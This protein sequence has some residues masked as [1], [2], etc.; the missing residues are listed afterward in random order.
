MLGVLGASEG[1]DN[2]EG[3]DTRA[4]DELLLSGALVYISG[5]LA[6]LVPLL[7]RLGAAPADVRIGP[8]CERLFGGLGLARGDFEEGWWQGMSLSS[9][10]FCIAIQPEVEALDAELVPYGGAA[11]FI[12]DDGLVI[13]PPEVVFAAIE[14]F[15][16]RI[17]D[18]LGLVGCRQEHGSSCSGCDRS[19]VVA[20]HI[21]GCDARGG[22]VAAGDHTAGRAGAARCATC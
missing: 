8:L 6:H 19:A 20:C 11:R 17:L 21:S 18:S 22:E 15:A 4:S 5:W 13:G 1:K 9:L 3:K 7:H 2:S 10:V 12:M 14:R 16:Q